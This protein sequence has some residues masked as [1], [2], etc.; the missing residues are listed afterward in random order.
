MKQ[1]FQSLSNGQSDLPD[2]PVPALSSGQLLIRTDCSLLS[3]GTERMLVDFGRA[4]WI[5]KALQQPDKVEQVLLK[6]RTDGVFSTFDSVRSKLD[7]PLPLGYCNVGK[8]LAVGSGV[9]GFRVG[10]RVA[11]NG[12]HAELFCVYQHLCSPIPSEVLQGQ[13]L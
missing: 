3:S 5:D 4:N 1:L 9:S 2:L 10:D 11:S 7:Q 6:A 8:V 13:G 12:P